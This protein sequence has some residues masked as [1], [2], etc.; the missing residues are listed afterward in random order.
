MRCWRVRF[1]RAQEES[2][3]GL[4]SVPV[5]VPAQVH[6]ETIWCATSEASHVP[7]SYLFQFEGRRLHNMIRLSISPPDSHGIE[8]DPIRFQTIDDA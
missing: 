2:W 5:P 4:V 6:A 7:I 8:L 1:R 3:A